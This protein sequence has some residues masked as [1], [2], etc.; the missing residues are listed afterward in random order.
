M[1][2]WKNA[3]GGLLMAVAVATALIALWT[4]LAHLGGR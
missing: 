2:D 4:L 3:G 1:N